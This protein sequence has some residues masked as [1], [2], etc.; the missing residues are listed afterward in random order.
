MAQV[1]IKIPVEYKA[2]YEDGWRYV[3]YYGG[4]YCFRGDTLVRTDTGNMRIDE[5]S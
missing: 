4:R 1:E 3:V 2:L 5:V